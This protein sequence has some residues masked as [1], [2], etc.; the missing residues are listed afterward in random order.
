MIWGWGWC[1]RGAAERPPLQSNSSTAL[2]WQTSTQ[3]LRDPETKIRAHEKHC[4]HKHLF[5]WHY[6]VHT[7]MWLFVCGMFD[8]C[9]QQCAGRSYSSWLLACWGAPPARW[10]CRCRTWWPRQTQWTDGLHPR[11]SH[12]GWSDQR[13]TRRETAGSQ[14]I[15]KGKTSVTKINIIDCHCWVNILSFDGFPIKP[16]KIG[17][18]K[19]G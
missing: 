4:Q 7:L 2:S 16:E 15:C 19:V 5:A 18:M 3:C 8:L 12:T 1:W 9:S 14:I 13:L 11:L 17:F 6:L 10:C